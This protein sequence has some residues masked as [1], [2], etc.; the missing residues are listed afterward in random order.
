MSKSINSVA[1]LGNVGRD[2]ET[3][4]LPSGTVASTFSLA[5]SERYKDKDGEWK[6]VSEW[7]NIVSYG[8]VAEV[9]RDY[10]SKG[11]KLY[12]Q[13][14]LTTRSWEKDGQKHYRTEVVVSEIVL[15]DGKGEKKQTQA[16]QETVSD[17]DIPW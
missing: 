1:L 12:I 6:D 9:I 11:S 17:D 10:V 16:P 7:H 4:T 3:K 5:T 8:K 14:K 2:P 13:G 15:L